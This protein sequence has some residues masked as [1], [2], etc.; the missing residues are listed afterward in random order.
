MTIMPSLK[1]PWLRALSRHPRRAAALVIGLWLSWVGWQAYG[2]IFD[3][4]LSEADVSARRLQVDRQRLEQLQ[5]RLATY[6]QP[7]PPPG[8]K[9]NAFKTKTNQESIP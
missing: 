9:T 5:S 6:H 8:L 1:Q 7:A 4:R 3:R 2:W